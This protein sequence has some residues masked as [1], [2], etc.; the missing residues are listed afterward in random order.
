MGSG[1]YLK[2]AAR[3]YSTSIISCSP[4]ATV[5]LCSILEP[6]HWVSQM[7]DCHCIHECFSVHSCVILTI[8]QLS[9]TNI[10]VWTWFCIATSMSSQS[11]LQCLSCSPI[12]PHSYLDLN[13][14]LGELLKFTHFQT[15]FTRHSEEFQVP[16]LTEGC[17]IT[18]T[19]G[20][21]R[22]PFTHLQ[23]WENSN[24][25]PLTGNV[26]VWNDH[27]MTRICDE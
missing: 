23:H 2:V 21:R 10:D 13:W 20:F 26:T 12:H 3:Y 5:P 4:A 15:P 8:R 11:L 25:L 27:K 1:R 6:S 17:F 18:L 16:Y 9:V 24:F 7:G 22:G 19:A 14:E